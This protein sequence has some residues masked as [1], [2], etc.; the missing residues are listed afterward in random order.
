M[1]DLVSIVVPIYNIENNVA[2]CIESIRSQIYSNLEI[3]LVDDG[4][5]DSSG[6]ICDAFAHKDSR[7]IVIHRQNGG[8]SAARNTGIEAAHGKY[9]MF[10]DGDDI[11]SRY[12]VKLLLASYYAYPNNI[13]SLHRY[14]RISDYDYNFKKPTYKCVN[15]D[16]EDIVKGLLSGDFKEISAWGKLFP[17]EKVKKLKFTEGR[18]YFEDKY[19]LFQYFLKFNGNV[20]QFHDRLY[21]YYVREGSIT[22]SGFSNSMFNILYFYRQMLLLTKKYRPEYIEIAEYNDVKGRLAILKSIIRSHK[23]KSEYNVFYRVKMNL[24]KLYGDKPLSF[25]GRYKYEIMALKMSDY[26]YILCVCL[27]DRFM[28]S[29]KR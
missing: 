20:C 21:G 8:L 7:I 12:S 4:S 25:F 24:L 23:Y 19:Y 14:C 22:N 11:I 27:F 9:I 18:T 26:L 2:Y 13:L 16:S 28:R 3:I 1:S 10:L 29:K 5:T 6:Q 15:L 17:Y